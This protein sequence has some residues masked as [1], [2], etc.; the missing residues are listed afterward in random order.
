MPKPEPEPEPEHTRLKTRNVVRGGSG[1]DDDS[2]ADIRA[3]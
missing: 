1:K 3:G 2:R